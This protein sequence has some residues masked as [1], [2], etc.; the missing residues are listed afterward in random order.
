MLWAPG[1]HLLGPHAIKSNPYLLLPFARCRRDPRFSGRPSY[2]STYA[3]V[4][5]L[6]GHLNNFG[7]TAA[8]P[9]KRL[10]RL[11]KELS[12]ADKA[13]QRGR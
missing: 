8:I 13:L 5:T 11:G 1:C 12:D 10:E 6:V 9:K 7:F 2:G 4:N 3:A